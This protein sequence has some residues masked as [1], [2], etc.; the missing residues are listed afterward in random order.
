MNRYVLL[1]SVAAICVFAASLAEAAPTATVSLVNPGSGYVSPGGTVR[2][3]SMSAFS[4]V[5]SVYYNAGYV[6]FSAG[7]YNLNVTGATAFED[8]LNGPTKSFCIDLWDSAPK[9]DPKPYSI[10]DV[11]EAPDAGAGPMG[12]AK[13]SDITKLLSKYWVNK[14]LSPLEA[15]AIQSAV[16]EIVDENASSYDLDAGQFQTFGDSSDTSTVKYRA[17][18]M[19]AGI[20]TGWTGSETL[21]PFVALSNPGNSM[22]Q[23]QDYV[24]LVPIP[25]AVLLGLLGMAVAGTK[26]RKHA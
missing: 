4:D 11:W 7:V 1:M 12:G 17:E 8:F 22:P 5:T 21:Y 23:W 19:L 14:S 13:A 15:M 20:T 6:D 24:V 10:V 16:W 26:W 3:T 18:Q 2:V 25:G 9:D